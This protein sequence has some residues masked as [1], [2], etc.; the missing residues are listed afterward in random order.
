[1]YVQLKVLTYTTI[2]NILLSQFLLETADLPQLLYAL[3]WSVIQTKSG[4]LSTLA[5]YP[6]IYLFSVQGQDLQHTLEAVWTKTHFT[7]LSNSP[8]NRL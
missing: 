8:D 1:M 7:K 6:K 5:L 4:E 2:K 3:Y